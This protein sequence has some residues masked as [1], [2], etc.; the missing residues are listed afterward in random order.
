MALVRGTLLLGRKENNTDMG[1]LCM[2]HYCHIVHLWSCSWKTWRQIGICQ[3][4]L[5]HSVSHETTA[6]FTCW[7]AAVN[8][9]AVASAFGISCSELS[10]LSLTHTLST[11]LSLSVCPSLSLFLKETKQ[12]QWR[13]GGFSNLQASP[14]GQGCTQESLQIKKA[15]LDRNWLGLIW[16]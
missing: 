2:I 9:L 14:R 3:F 8:K 5:F 10:L 7:N 16:C 11:S 15:P 4:K 6:A 1:M 12:T 13:L